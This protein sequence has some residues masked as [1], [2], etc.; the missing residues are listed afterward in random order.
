MLPDP[1]R[2]M[3]ASHVVRDPETGE[4]SWPPPEIELELMELGLIPRRKIERVDV[5][6]KP[7]RRRKNRF[8]YTQRGTVPEDGAYP[9]GKQPSRYGE[10]TEEED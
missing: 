8:V 6:P 4:I 1:V 7:D 3:E 10:R 9:A 5:E 2:I